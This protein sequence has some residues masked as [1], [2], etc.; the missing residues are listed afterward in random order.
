V[1]VE[2]M[3]SLG[4]WRTEHVL[5]HGV[6]VFDFLVANTQSNEIQY[7]L[8][9]EAPSARLVL[10]NAV[11]AQGNAESAAA[12]VPSLAPGWFRCPR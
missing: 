12:A 11:R 10:T 2:V 5:G 3:S 9:Y 1:P 7:R 8:T 6:R 4:D